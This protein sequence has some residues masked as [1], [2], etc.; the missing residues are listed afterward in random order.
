MPQQDAKRHFT[1]PAIKDTRDPGKKDETPA[2]LLVDDEK[3]FVEA[4]S[5]RL[6]ARGLPCLTAFSGG[7]ALA[8]LDGQE[9]GSSHGFG[10]GLGRELEVVLLDL[11][12]PGMHGLEVLRLIK[13][14]RPDVEVLLLTGDSN[15]TVAA[16]GMRRG[17]G[18]YLVKPV[19]FEVLLESIHKARARAR[20]HKES[21]RASEAVK[22]M[23]LGTL[24]AGVGHE[25]NNPLQVIMQRSEWLCE[26][27]A[28][29]ESG[30]LDLPEMAKTAQTIADQARRCGEITARLLDLAHKAK[31]HKAETKLAELTAKVVARMRHRAET[32]GVELVVD[33]APDCPALPCSPA[34]MEPVLEHL[35]QNALDGIEARQLF[36]GEFSE[37]METQT[38][39][40]A[41][42][43]PEPVPEQGD[44]GTQ[45]GEPPGDFVRVTA[46]V[47][48]DTL[49]IVVQDSGEGIKPEHLPHIYEPFF[50]TRA[51]GK[52][53]GLGLTACHSI[54]AA[55][56]GSI[57]HT[58]VP[59]FPEFPDKSPAGAIFTVSIP[60][61]L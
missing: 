33:I 10:H 60:L 61:I 19:E 46:R 11:N 3:A 25:I 7:E 34:E 24:A 59:P 58:P 43:V 26:L 14:R 56:R 44:M 36:A 35:L 18:D 16:R 29:A 53:A 52:G 20:E 49:V 57:R 42:P 39:A 12:M 17:A 51:M 5:F 55:L 23:A 15:L 27:V 48:N 28:D 1:A 30:K 2:L 13:S 4:L 54:I 40:S 47:E 32:F 31:H 9:Q 45:M 8:L 6:A 38:T 37:T 50:S 22:L 21:L 41:P